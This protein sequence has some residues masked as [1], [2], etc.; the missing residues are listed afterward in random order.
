MSMSTSIHNNDICLFSKLAYHLAPP[1]RNDIILAEVEING[2][3]YDDI[4]RVIAVP[5]DTVFLKD[6]TLYVN[7]EANSY[8]K[9]GNVAQFDMDDEIKLDRDEYF[10]MG[11]KQSHA[12]DSRS[13]SYGLLT[14]TEIKGKFLVT[15]SLPSN[16]FTGTVESAE[17]V[18]DQA[19][20]P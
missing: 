18:N 20:R 1:A 6:G 10:V 7:G 3:T 4:V 15:L 14:E 9:T 11:D 12:T 2:L 13:K 8:F 19:E 17:P 5:G 16:H